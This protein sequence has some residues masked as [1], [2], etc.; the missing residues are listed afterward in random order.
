MYR[1]LPKLEAAQKTFERLD[2]Y[3]CHRIENRG[4]TL[5]PGG[6]T[7]MEG[8]DL[9]RVGIK[10]YNKD[11]YQ[12]HLE[13]S[14]KAADGLWKNSFR[15][16]SDGDR[17]LLGVFLDT[18]MGASKLIQ[19]KAQ[20]NSLGCAGCHKVGNFGGDA[21]V[22]LTREGEKDP[23]TLNYLGVQGEHKLG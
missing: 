17:D 23:G 12:A 10:G 9:S 4:G 16:I 21:G 18:Q 7:G 3:A 5:R 6:V 13:N 20:F 8:P 14:Q 22:E 2:C 15:E 11:W 1:T 19:A